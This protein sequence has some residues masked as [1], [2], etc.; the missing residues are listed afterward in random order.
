MIRTRE[1]RFKL[2][3]WLRFDVRKKFFTQKQGVQLNKL[4]HKALQQ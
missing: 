2:K 1:V 3:V 4:D